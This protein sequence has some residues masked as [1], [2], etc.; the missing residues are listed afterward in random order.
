MRNRKSTLALMLCGFA[1][2]LTVAGQTAT[3]TVQ[4][5]LGYP[6]T[7]RLL[8]LHSDD[9][10]MSHSVNRATEE[11]FAN[12]SITSASILVPCPWFPEAAKFAKEHPELD[13]GIHLALNSEWTGMRWGPVSGREKVPSL[14]D[15]QGFLPL[16]TGEVAKN[17]KMN[18]VETELRSQIEMA[19]ALGISISHF[20]TH[21][22]A[23]AESPEL[24]RVYQ[25]LGREY[26]LPV[27]L[28][29]EKL[30]KAPQLAAPAENVLIDAI[31]TLDPGIAAKD[32]TNWY[33]Q[34]LAAL[35]P[36]VYEA[37]VHL[38]Y[39]DDEMR[40]ATG[41]HPDWG[42]AWRQQDME[43]LKSAEFRQFLKDQGF[44]LVTWRE[45]A[46][47]LPTDYGKK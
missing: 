27:L 44:I 12:K 4:E 29:K 14:L 32:W 46:K 18:E 17:A 3:P 1:S 13:F 6:A 43:T 47:A 33:K 36:G 9:F 20:D 15:L 25:K 21:M 31:V 28:V 24:F 2:A 41:D 37:V 40:G 11:G 30:S 10:G 19:R 23:L 7:A 5:R 42:A 22:N 39:D 8:V 45:L 26:G 16:D 34:Q 38:G 35:K